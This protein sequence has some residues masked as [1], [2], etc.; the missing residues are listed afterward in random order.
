MS[1]PTVVSLIGSGAL[2]ARQERWGSR[3]KWRIRTSSLDRYIAANGS[4]TGHSTLPRR[5]A[6]LER[7]LATVLPGPVEP[8]PLKGSEAGVDDLR[9]LLVNREESLVRTRHA[10][11]ALAEADAER[12]EVVRLLLEA[13]QAA[14]RADARRR[15]AISSLSEALAGYE[16]PGHLGHLP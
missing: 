7:Q 14:E 16:R 5:V 9:A 3:F 4:Q 13:L 10:S 8:T 11:Q 15:E 12:A 1:I 6:A 2:E